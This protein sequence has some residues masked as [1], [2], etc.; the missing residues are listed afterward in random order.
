ML[1]LNSHKYRLNSSDFE[2]L[3]GGEM[4]WKDVWGFTVL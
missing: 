3:F 2:F 4:F 1:N